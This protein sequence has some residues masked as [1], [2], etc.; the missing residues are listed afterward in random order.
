[1]TEPMKRVLTIRSESISRIAIVVVAVTAT[2]N[3]AWFVT[4]YLQIR[5]DLNQSMVRRD[6]M[7]GAALIIAALSLAAKRGFGLMLSLIALL[8]VLFEYIRWYFWTKRLIE[9]LGMPGIP[10]W[11]PQAAHLWGGTTWNVLVL[12]IVSILVVWEMGI[13]VRLLKSSDRAVGSAS[14]GQ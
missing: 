10:P 12:I 2:L 7:V 11:V 1:M 14:S 5:G 9:T 3:L 8:W 4:K 13:L 6:W